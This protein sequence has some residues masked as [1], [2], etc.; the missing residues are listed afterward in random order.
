M[1]AS[2][3][4]IC[5]TNWAWPNWVRRDI[6]CCGR[7]HEFPVRKPDAGNPPVRFDER[8]VETEQG[9]ILWP[10]QPK[11]PVTSMAHLNHRAT[12]R[13]YQVPI[14][15]QNPRPLAWADRTGRSGREY[16]SRRCPLGL[17]L[18]QSSVGRLH[19]KRHSITIKSRLK[20][21]SNSA[22]SSVTSTLSM[23]RA[24]SRSSPR[25]TGGST[26]TTMPASSV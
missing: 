2:P 10:R 16:P 17:D 21:D 11:G 15:A 13:L 23:I 19:S 1:H 7:K 8:E 5:T 12:S 22:P 18:R 3:T 6:V 20:R 25:N 9:G 14:H 26:V 24:P 4:R